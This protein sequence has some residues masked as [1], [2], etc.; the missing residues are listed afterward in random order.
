M[1]L[2]PG[3]A[4]SWSI[5]IFIETSN[6][7]FR[8]IDSIFYF[9]I[10]NYHF[11]DQLPHIGVPSVD[12]CMMHCL[13]NL[14]HITLN[15]LSRL[16]NIIFFRILGF[17]KNSIQFYRQQ[18]F[19]LFYIVNFL[20]EMQVWCTTLHT[21]YTAHIW[22]GCGVVFLQLN[23]RRMFILLFSPVYFHIVTP[24]AHPVCQ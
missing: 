21:T 23:R 19:N 6:G 3:R 5:S 20:F 12:V 10:V 9:T 14:K 7:H 16:L 1:Q 15:M 11:Q 13:Y 24:I 17:D 22:I 4:I 18:L 2:V 8:S